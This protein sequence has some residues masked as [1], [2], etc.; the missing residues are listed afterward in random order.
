MEWIY[1]SNTLLQHEISH[2]ILLLTDVKDSDIYPELRL[3]LNVS[4]TD[5]DVNNTLF[6]SLTVS[7]LLSHTLSA[8]LQC[9]TVFCVSCSNCTV[10]DLTHMWTKH[11]QTI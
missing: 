9:I 8:R 1:I 4:C 11:L 5:L 7:F 2:I 3:K 6:P 10:L